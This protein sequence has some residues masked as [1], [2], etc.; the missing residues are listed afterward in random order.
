L[1]IKAE[2]INLDVLQ[3]GDKNTFE[4]NKHVNDLIQ[5]VVQD[6]QNNTI[7]MFLVIMQMV[8]M[9]IWSLSKGII[10]VFRIMGLIYLKMKVI[11]KATAL[12]L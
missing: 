5:K 2:S 11:K 4:L 7:K 9:L 3:N 8:R 12:Q 10:K 1:N 6:G